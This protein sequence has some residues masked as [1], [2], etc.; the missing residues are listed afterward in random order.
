MDQPSSQSNLALVAAGV[1]PTPDVDVLVRWNAGACGLWLLQHRDALRRGGERWVPQIGDI[2]R[3]WRRWHFPNGLGL[4]VSYSAWNIMPGYAPDPTKYSV[5]EHEV[6]A[7]RY[8]VVVGGAAPQDAAEAFGAYAGRLEVSG[9]C[10]VLEAKWLHDGWRFRR[11][12]TPALLGAL[13]E[14]AGLAEGP[15][16]DR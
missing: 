2:E 12:D 16:E 15:E 11:T 9:G 3:H 8:R 13:R 7:T 14:T 4:A 10:D 1:V 6:E 5:D